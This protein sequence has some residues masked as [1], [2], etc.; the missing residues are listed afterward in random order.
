MNRITKEQ[1]DQI[2]LV[3]I[4]TIALCVGLW[5]LLII[6]QTAALAQGQTRIKEAKAKVDKAS[7]LVRQKDD[8]EKVLGEDQRKLEK[9]EETMASGDLYAW[10]ILTLNKFLE[11]HK[12]KISNYSRESIGSIGMLPAFP[13]ASATFTIP[14]S[15][16]FHD[17]GTFVAEFENQFPYFQIQNLELTAGGSGQ[18]DNEMLGFRMEIVT[19]L[20]PTQ[21]LSP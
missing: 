19:L 3:I 1:R 12:I 6:P 10:A 7:S 15:A 18:T 2:V 13:Y 17:F 14:G 9:I 21:P 5:Y 8:I 20:R 11:G 4:S 16:Y